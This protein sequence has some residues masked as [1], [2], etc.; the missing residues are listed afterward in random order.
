MELH[1]RNQSEQLPYEKLALLGIDREKA[2]NLPPRGKGKAGIRRGHTA[3][4]GVDKC[5]KR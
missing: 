3:D 2:D 4:A 5:P 1:N